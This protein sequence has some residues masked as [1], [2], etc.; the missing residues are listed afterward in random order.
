MDTAIV[1]L[2]A[3]TTSQIPNRPA[4]VLHRVHP[5]C[6]TTGAPN[7]RQPP[8]FGNLASPHRYRELSPR[9]PVGSSSGRR[10]SAEWTLTAVCRVP[11]QSRVWTRSVHATARTYASVMHQPC[12]N[13]GGIGRFLYSLWAAKIAKKNT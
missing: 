1:L 4:C 5:H 8:S 6:M 11:P 12:A 9:S 10:L 7:F 13:L 2:D 3:V